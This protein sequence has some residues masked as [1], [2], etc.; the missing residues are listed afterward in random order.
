MA[1]HAASLWSADERALIDALLNQLVPSRDDGSIPAAGAVGVGAFIAR[2]LNEDQTLQSP[3]AKGLARAN[4]IGA[5]SEDSV[6]R[7]EIEQP[8]FF[9]LLQRLAYMGYYSRPDIRGLL[10]LSAKPVH[11]DGY[12]VPIEPEELMADL[13]APVRS[14]GQCYRDA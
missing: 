7:I 12:D 14:R 13:T 6:T 4:E 2:A 1:D 9:K 11:P 3:F 10:G 8:E 5:G